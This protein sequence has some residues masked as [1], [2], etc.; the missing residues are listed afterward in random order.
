VSPRGGSPNAARGAA[1]VFEVPAGAGPIRE[2]VAGHLREL[3]RAGVLA[4]GEL[5]P[6]VHDARW[7][8]LNYNT[9][10]RAYRMLRVE[11]L[12]DMRRAAGTFVR[13]RLPARLS[14]SGLE[15][16]L[17]VEQ[18]GELLG[19]RRVVMQMPAESGTVEVG[20]RLAQ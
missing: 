9:V 4:P 20:V 3:I 19:G 1:A 12:L 7:G 8:G 2:R 18:V 14:G 6:G 17:T 10:Y 13:G 15:L 16:S 5:L 11:G